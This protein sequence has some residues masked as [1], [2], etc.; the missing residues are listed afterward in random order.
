MGRA[1]KFSCRLG[2]HLVAGRLHAWVRLIR[3]IMSMVAW[4]TM[5]TP[6]VAQS[7]HPLAQQ[8]S[9]GSTST[10]HPAPERPRFGLVL[11]GGGARGLAHV[12]VLKVLE[13]ER[14]PVGKPRDV[15]HGAKKLG[16]SIYLGGDTAFGPVYLAA[17]TSPKIGPTL[18]LF[19]GRP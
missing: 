14:I 7:H 6:A 12:G 1:V 18:M 9:A 15:W 10:G 5:A 11:S 8:P 4:L 17:D 3:P 2:W 19:V 16:A 13:R